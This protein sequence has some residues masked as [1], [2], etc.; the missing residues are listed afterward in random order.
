[1]DQRFSDLERHGL[2]ERMIVGRKIVLDEEDFF[3]DPQEW[4]EEV[5]VSLAEEL[6][7]KNMSETHWSILRFL[8]RYYL[9]NGRSPLNRQIKEGTGVSIME[10]EVLF[11]GGIKYGARRLAGLP[12]PRGCA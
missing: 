5:A 6:G 8:R 3:W 11:P 2:K 1:M 10:M 12:N 9:E 4:S 7:L